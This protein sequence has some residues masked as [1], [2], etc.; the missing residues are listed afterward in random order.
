M[1]ANM[2]QFSKGFTFSAN[3]KLLKNKLLYLLRLIKKERYQIVR[4]CII[5]ES[6]GMFNKEWYLK[7]NPDVAKSKMSP[8]YHYCRYGWQE[9]RSPSKYFDGEKY[10]A[11]NQD[12]KNSRIN[13]LV[14]WILRGSHEGRKYYPCFGNSTDSLVECIRTSIHFDEQWYQRKHEISSNSN[15]AN[16]YLTEGWMLGYNPSPNF[17]GN[18]YLDFYPD[19]ANAKMCPLIHYERYGANEMRQQPSTLDSPLDVL[20]LTTTMPTDGV[21]IWRCIFI[22]E[23]LEKS[24]L[25]VEIESTLKQTPDFLKKLITSS[26]VIFN[27]PRRNGV[28]ANII[29]CLVKWRKRFCFDMDDLI[30]D[31]YFAGSG[32]YKSGLISYDHLMAN[33][34]LTS[35]AYKFT[36][37]MT[38]STQFLSSSMSQ[39]FGLNTI[40]LPNTIP[41]SYCSG[42]E[43]QPDENAFRLVYTSGSPTHLNDFSSIYIDLLNF[44]IRHTDVTLT[45]IGRAIAL[46]EFHLVDD[47]VKFLDYMDFAAML[48]TYSNHDLALVPLEYNE[49]NNAKSNIKYIESASVAVPVLARDCDEFK[50]TIRD[51]IN[52]FL[53]SEGE[54]STKLE[55]IYQHRETLTKIGENA[56]NDVKEN[57]S[58]NLPIPKNLE[59]MICS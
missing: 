45:I 59:A 56:L 26:F 27:R 14:H 33:T 48:E 9:G 18:K 22:K 55:N 44:M 46:Q 57:H 30:D 54:F 32:R 7:Y 49:F 51:G 4:D 37:T 35:D 40:I 19:V 6:S 34:R 41:I 1:I 50:S 29:R 2:K 11:D 8:I 53:Y 21:Y 58:T 20:I 16:H 3:V 52:G 25:R 5:V 43:Y 42:R 24:G 17:D 47:R 12:V 28:A 15:I 36:E 38:V 39:H 10:L 31:E 23:W 13:P